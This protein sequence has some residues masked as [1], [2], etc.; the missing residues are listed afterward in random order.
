[1]E[2]QDG[3]TETLAR[4]LRDIAARPGCHVLPPRGPVAVPDTALIPD[5]LR[6]LYQL[7]GGALLFEDS[8][9]PRRVCGPG[10]FVPASPRLLGE[11]AAHQVAREEPG[12][13]TNGCYVIVDGGRGSSTEPHVVI[14]LA[15]ER[16]GRCYAAAWDTYGLVGEMP[17]VA[18]NVADLLLLLLREG[19]SEAMPSTTHDR[20][21]Y[22]L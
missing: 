21:A 4:V 16:A 22:D 14:D 3:T 9:F 5:D 13:L 10:T 20:D 1:M 7:C 8:P 2:P 17:V 15:P 12:D 18:T 6:Q 19:G 11:Q